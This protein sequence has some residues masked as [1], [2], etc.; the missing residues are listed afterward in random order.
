M[1]KTESRPRFISLKIRILNIVSNIRASSFEFKQLYNYFCLIFSFKSRK[2]ALFNDPPLDFF[3]FVAIFEPFAAIG[4]D[5]PFFAVFR[6][7]HGVVA[8][9]RLF[10]DFFGF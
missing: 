4:D 7:N 2:R 3:D 8:V 9:K 5:E 6:P 10:N 1:F